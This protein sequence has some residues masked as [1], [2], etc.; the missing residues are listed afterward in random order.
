MRSTRREMPRR[1]SSDNSEPSL[2]WSLPKAGVVH[3]ACLLSSVS[4][5]HQEKLVAATEDAA[6]LARMRYQGGATGYLE[7]LTTDSNPFPRN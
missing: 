7:A 4:R 2:S 3:A 1:W 5:E 6:R